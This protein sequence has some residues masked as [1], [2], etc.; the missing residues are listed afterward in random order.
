MKRLIVTLLAI[1][2][3][4]I[5]TQA[6][7]NNETLTPTVYSLDSD[8]LTLYVVGGATTSAASCQVFADSMSVTTADGLYPGTTWFVFA[9]SNK[10]TISEFITYLN[11]ISVT[12]PGAEGGIVATL[13]S[14]AY[15]NNVTEELTVAA[16]QSIKG[17]SAAKTLAADRFLGLSYTLPASGTGWRQQYHITGLSANATYTS[18]SVTLNI[19]N[20]TETSNTNLLRYKLNATTTETPI[21]FLTSGNLAGSN[22]TAM[23]FDVVG[24]SWIS[25]GYIN[26]IGHKK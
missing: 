26:I 2:S 15:E 9:D 18:G 17:A 3:L 12:T 21:T 8:A 13:P 19:Y 24:S 16:S 14:G 10:D 7:E 5:V 23:R 11:A 25:A 1:C 6:R 4:A 22:D 20:G